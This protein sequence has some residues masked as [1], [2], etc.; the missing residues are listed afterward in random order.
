MVSANYFTKCG[1]QLINASINRRWSNSW[2]FMCTTCHKDMDNWGRN[3]ILIVCLSNQ[4][5]LVL[6]IIV[7]REINLSIYCWNI[8]TGTLRLKIMNLFLAMPLF[9]WHPHFHIKNLMI[10]LNCIGFILWFFK[11]VIFNLPKATR[12][13]YNC[14]I[15]PELNHFSCRT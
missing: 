8:P 6:G 7:E 9:S 12:N 15:L 10:Y 13:R 11:N 14:K 3:I 2:K 1:L 4:N 5:N